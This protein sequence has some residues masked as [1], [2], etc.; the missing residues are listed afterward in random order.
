MTNIA[1]Y[2]TLFLC[3]IGFFVA[4]WSI[5]S[6]FN[7]HNKNECYLAGRT[8]EDTKKKVIAIKIRKLADDMDEISEQ[9]NSLKEDKERLYVF[10]IE[11]IELIGSIKNIINEWAN[12]I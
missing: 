4:V 10:S 6:T 9:M 7:E 12:E 1:I 2:S 11:S 5:V 3:A 8:R